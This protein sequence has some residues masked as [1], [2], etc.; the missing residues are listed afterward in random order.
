MTVT[1]PP[2]STFPKTKERSG[3]S[4]S[5]EKLAWALM[6]KS[7]SRRYIPS[8]LSSVYVETL[9]P[10]PQ[11]IIEI[12]RPPL[13]VYQ[14]VIEKT[15]G[16]SIRTQAMGTALIRAPA[17]GQAKQGQ[18]NQQGQSKQQQ[19]TPANVTVQPSATVEVQ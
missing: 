13:P 6:L 11:N 8:S 3:S 10:F 16:L 12:H 17:E 19:S 7:I 4:T 9:T 1:S 18:Q 5:S 15:R 2:A 14:S